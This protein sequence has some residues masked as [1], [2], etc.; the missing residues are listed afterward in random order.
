[1][2][3]GGQLTIFV[4]IG[5]VLI[6]FLSLSYFLVIKFWGKQTRDTYILTSDNVASLNT[7]MTACLE[8]SSSDAVKFLAMRGGFLISEYRPDYATYKTPLFNTQYYIYN[9][10]DLTPSIQELELQISSYNKIFFDQCINNFDAF[11]FRLKYTFNEYY[12]RILDDEVYTRLKVQLRYET[13]NIISESTD[14]KSSIKT[15]YGKIANDAI[16]IAKN[17]KNKK[18]ITFLE[19]YDLS[20]QTI[21]NR[22]ILFALYG[23]DF[24]YTFAVYDLKNQPPVMELIENQ[25]LVLN[26]PYYLEIDSIDPDLDTLLYFDDTPLFDIYTDFPANGHSTTGIIEFIPTIRGTFPVTITVT[27]FIHNDTQTIVFNVK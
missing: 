9:S 24:V 17:Y 20:Y 5:L 19:N 6:I 2:K 25:N 8:R 27:D 4:I 11:P 26:Q 10:G 22:N 3:R 15:N 14:I 1:M 18:D 7:Y 13:G 16:F 12:T 23:K 21:D